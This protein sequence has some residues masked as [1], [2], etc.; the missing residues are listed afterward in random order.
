MLQ[1]LFRIPLPGFL[2]DLLGR[3]FLSVFGFGLM[4][5]LAF[6]AGAQL[7]KYLARRCGFDGETFVNGALLGLLSG[8]V[9]ARLSHVLESLADPRS[10]EFARNGKTFAQNLGAMFNVSS[11]G[12]TFYGGFILATVVLILYARRKRIPVLKGMDIV[13]PALMVGLALGRVGCFLNGCCYG[14]QCEPGWA[15]WGV[16]FPYGSPAY[17][18]QVEERRILPDERLLDHRSGRP[19]LLSKDEIHARGLDVVMRRE[20]AH[21]VYPTQL[22]STFNSLL[23]TALLLAFFTLAPLPGRVFALMLMLEGA[24][25]FILEMLRVEPAVLGRWSFSM[26]IGAA[27]VAAGALMWF[28]CGWLPRGDKE[29]GGRI[30]VAPAG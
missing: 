4:L 10:H 13:A 25:R 14:E 2:Q 12:L 26:A 15:N 19:R 9:G 7:M 18:E 30:A 27:L 17:V 8:V 1:E 28:A 23:V 11:G 22:Y 3:P 21:A 6:L 5:V 29:T 20:H 24:S 16:E